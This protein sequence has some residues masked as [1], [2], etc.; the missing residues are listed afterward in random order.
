MGNAPQ[1]NAITESIRPN[2]DK[3]EAWR[4]LHNDGLYSSCSSADR[5]TVIK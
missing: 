3:V 4:K 2:G 1:K 5:C